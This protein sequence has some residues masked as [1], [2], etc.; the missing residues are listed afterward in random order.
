MVGD[1]LKCECTLG[2]VWWQDISRRVMLDEAGK[3]GLSQITGVFECQ[4]KEAWLYFA[5]IPSIKKKKKAF[6]GLL[7]GSAG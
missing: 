6:E 1:A 3:V 2:K 4:S 5:G 7:G